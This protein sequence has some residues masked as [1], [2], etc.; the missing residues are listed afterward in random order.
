MPRAAG[1]RRDRLPAHRHQRAA[2]ALPARRRGA[3]GYA[4][5]R[6][7]G[8]VRSGFTF[9]GPFL[10]PARAGAHRP[11]G[12]V[13]AEANPSSGS[14]C[15]TSTACG[16]MTTAPE[17]P[18]ALRAHRPGPRPRDRGKPGPRRRNLRSDDRRDLCRRHARDPPLQRD[19]A[20]GHRGPGAPGAALTDDRVVV[21]LIADGAHCHPAAPPPGAPGRRP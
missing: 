13:R 9:E 5:R 4:G 21:C 16:L 18:G 14:T 20:L 3:G 7:R 6:G 2:R 10:S 17:R 19:V 8:G 15:W 11:A 12:I 1:H